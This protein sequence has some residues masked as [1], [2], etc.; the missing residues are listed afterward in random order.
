MKYKFKDLI[1]NDDF[2]L[3][4]ENCGTGSGKDF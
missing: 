1:K 4:E 2:K 3:K